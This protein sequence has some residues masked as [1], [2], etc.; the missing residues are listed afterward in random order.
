VA[1]SE[2]VKGEGEWLYER[3]LHLPYLQELKI[4]VN[5]G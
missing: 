1:V 5:H 2:A 3:H 4:K